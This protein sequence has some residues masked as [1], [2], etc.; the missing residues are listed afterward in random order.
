LANTPLLTAIVGSS[1]KGPQAIEVI[2]EYTKGITEYYYYKDQIL[3][4]L[5]FKGKKSEF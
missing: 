4:L 2:E 3:D 5:V 1:I